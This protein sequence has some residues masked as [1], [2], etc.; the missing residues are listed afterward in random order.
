VERFFINQKNNDGVIIGGVRML[1]EFSPLQ[2]IVGVPGANIVVT[3]EALQIA[4]FDENEIN[5][6]GKIAN[7]ET[8]RRLVIKGGG[9]S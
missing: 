9:V 2:I 4:R 7:V 3:G 1:S 5:I 6:V 8:Q